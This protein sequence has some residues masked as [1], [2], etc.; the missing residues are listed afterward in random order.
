MSIA[1]GMFNG[2]FKTRLIGVIENGELIEFQMGFGVHM[3][4]P[5]GHQTGWSVHEELGMAIIQE[6]EG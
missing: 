4:D 1:N 6:T 3:V 2:R 5:R